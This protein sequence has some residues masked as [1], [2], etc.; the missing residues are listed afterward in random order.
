MQ[1]AH[2][3]QKDK[4][5]VNCMVVSERQVI[6]T[7]TLRLFPSAYECEALGDVG[8]DGRMNLDRLVVI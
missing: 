4:I 8:I 3:E 7:T 5:D 2:L 1:N 6:H